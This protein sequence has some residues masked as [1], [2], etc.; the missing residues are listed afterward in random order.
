MR[1]F[2]I[3]PRTLRL[4]GHVSVDRRSD[5]LLVASVDG[6]WQYKGSMTWERFGGGWNVSASIGWVPVISLRHI[7]DRDVAPWARVLV[8]RFEPLFAMEAEHVRVMREASDWFLEWVRDTVTPSPTSVDCIDCGATMPPD[9]AP[10]C[11]GC[12]A[13]RCQWCWRRKDSGEPG[14]FCP[15]CEVVE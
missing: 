5:D 8:R 1:T 4:G 12:K 3:P 9:G 6:G 2:D 7:S 11:D 14:L 15:R 13:Q 10:L